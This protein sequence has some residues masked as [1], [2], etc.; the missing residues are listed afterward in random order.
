MYRG[1]GSN[2]QKAMTR[3]LGNN[4]C[5]QLAGDDLLKKSVGIHMPPVMGDSKLAGD[6][7]NG[8]CCPDFP[9][10]APPPPSR[11]HRTPHHRAALAAPPSRS[12]KHPP[13]DRNAQPAMA[14][15]V[16]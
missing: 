5:W 4:G 7:Q 14:A 3:D 11:P 15:G 2:V 8:H 1:S 10:A 16:R 12:Q 9:A 6:R 13:P